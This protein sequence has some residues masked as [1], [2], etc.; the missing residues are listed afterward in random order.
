MITENIREYLEK[1]ISPSCD[2]CKVAMDLMIHVDKILN[3]PYIKSRS[4][5]DPVFINYVKTS[6]YDEI[7]ANLDT[8]QIRKELILILSSTT[9]REDYRLR[10]LQ[11]LYYISCVTD[12][13]NDSKLST[14]R[15]FQNFRDVVGKST[16]DFN[17]FLE[18]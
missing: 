7:E 15:E 3:M 14:D 12:A 5:D 4:F 1:N 9:G 11:V 2:F 18:E 13:K 16:D 17:I 8:G 6:I 10:S